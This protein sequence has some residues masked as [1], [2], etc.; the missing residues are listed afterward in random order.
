MGL[1][2]STK[3]DSIKLIHFKTVILMTYVGDFSI[4]M[5]YEIFNFLSASQTCHQHFSSSKSATNIDLT[6]W[7]WMTLEWRLKHTIFCHKIFHTHHFICY[8]AHVTIAYCQLV[9]HWKNTFWLIQLIVSFH[10]KKIQL[11]LFLKI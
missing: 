9:K 4:V 11:Q 1:V 8:I 2:W 10:H 3:D 5:I 6:D 7:N